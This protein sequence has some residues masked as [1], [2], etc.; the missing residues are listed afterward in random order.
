MKTITSASLLLLALSAPAHAADPE[1]AETTDEA[2]T[3]EAT[4]ESA[5][6]AAEEPDCSTLEEEE[7]TACEAHKAEQETAAPAATE[8]AKGG[9]AKRSNTNRMEAES[10]DE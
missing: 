2:T 6:E 5:E 1:P 4:E 7:T 9:K 10:T 8:P 3:E